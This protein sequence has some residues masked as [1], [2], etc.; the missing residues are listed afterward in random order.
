MPRAEI[1]YDDFKVKAFLDANI[2][3]ECRPLTEL[4]WREID[5]EGPIIVLITPTDQE[6]RLEEA[7]RS[8]RQ[9]NPCSILNPVEY[10]TI[11][12]AACMVTKI[13]AISQ[14]PCPHPDDRCS[15]EW[16][17]TDDAGRFEYI[18]DS[19]A[20]STCRISA[21]YRTACINFALREG[22]LNDTR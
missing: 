8:Y 22:R 15:D 14:E 21:H 4:P 10:R 18:N 7:R 9:N 13:A 1:K 2:I 19:R 20:C 17:P 11:R 3:L 12:R 5:A 16:F 6:N